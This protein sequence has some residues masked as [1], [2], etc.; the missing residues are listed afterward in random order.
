LLKTTRVDQ[1]I[2]KLKYVSRRASDDLGLGPEDPT[3]TREM[4]L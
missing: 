2:R 4:T 3:Q 1:L